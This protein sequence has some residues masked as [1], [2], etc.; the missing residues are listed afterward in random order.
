MGL[1]IGENGPQRTSNDSREESLSSALASHLDEITSR[2]TPTYEVHKKK[3]KGGKNQLPMS[4][5]SVTIASDNEDAIDPRDIFHHTTHPKEED[6][7]HVDM[8][9]WI[10]HIQTISVESWLPWGCGHLCEPAKKS[11]MGV[12]TRIDPPI[13]K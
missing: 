11:N 12:I 5:I 4:W 9:M 7:V 2:S 1:K 3:K 8:M 13:I 10:H 6:S